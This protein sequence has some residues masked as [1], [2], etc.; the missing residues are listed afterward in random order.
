MCCRLAPFAAGVNAGS[1]ASAWQQMVDP[2]EATAARRLQVN[3]AKLDY[4]D[5]AGL[6]AGPM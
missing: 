4:C 6:G 1:F 3:L 5:G 2:L